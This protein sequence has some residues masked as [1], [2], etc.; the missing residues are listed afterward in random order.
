MF[1]NSMDSIQSNKMQG[2]VILVYFGSILRVT[3]WWL[4]EISQDDRG[5]EFHPMPNGGPVQCSPFDCKLIYYTQQSKY[6]E[7][8]NGIELYERFLTGQKRY[9]Y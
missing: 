5:I 9:S 6:L 7:S 4:F 2:K 1:A 8:T 3:F